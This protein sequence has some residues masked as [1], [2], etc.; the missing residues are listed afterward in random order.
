MAGCSDEDASPSHQTVQHR[1]ADQT[2]QLS[3]AVETEPGRTTPGRTTPGRNKP[4]WQQTIHRRIADGQYRIRKVND[5]TGFRASNQAHGLRARFGPRNVRVTNVASADDDHTLL[6]NLARW[7]R[8]GNLVATEAGELTRGTCPNE[9]FVDARGE[10]I[11]RVEIRRDAI[12]EWWHN[13]SDGL[14]QGFTI[15]R[16][17]AGVWPVVVEMAV[18]G[19]TVEIDRDGQAADLVGDAGW[20]LRYN[21][22]RAWDASGTTLSARMAPVPGGLA[23][24]VDDTGAHYPITIDPLLTNPGWTAESDQQDASFGRSVSSAGDVNADG[25]DDVIVGAYGYDNGESNEGRA[26]VYF[27]SAGGL[28]T[29]AAWTAEGDQFGAHFGWSVSSAGDVNADGFDDVIVG[30]YG[31]SN[32]QNDEGR[33]FVYLG[34]AGGLATSPTWTAESDQ[35]SAQFGYSVSSAGDV[36]ADGFDDV[37]VGATNYDSGQLDEGRA[38][39]YLGSAGGLATSPAWT[40]EGDQDSAGFGGSVSSAGDVNAD[41]FDDVIAGAENYDNGQLDEGRAFVYLG[42]AGGLATSPAWTAEGDQ[43]SADFGGSVSSAG[44]VNADGFDDVVVGAYGYDNG[45][46]DEGQ[47]LVYLGSAGGLAT[48]PAWTAEGDSAYDY[49]GRSVSSAGDVN[50]DGFDDVIVGTRLYSNGQAQE[51]RA[52]VY[53]G[54]AGGLA[55]SPAWTAE[56]DQDG[57]F[58]G[59]SVSHAGDLNG[60][61]ASDVIVGADGYDNGQAQE[62]RAFVYHGEVVNRA[63]V[64][65][66]DTATT[67]ENTPVTVDVLANDS[68]PD[69][70]PL[71]VD[72]DSAPSSGTA[73]INADDTITYTPATNFTGTDS[74]TY[75]VDDTAAGSN[76]A[77][78]AVTVITAGTCQRV[79]CTADQACYAGTCFETCTGDSDCSNPDDACYDQRCAADPCEGVQC[80]TDQACYAGTCFE[81]CT[82]DSDCSNPD[83]AC[84]DQRCATDPCEGVQCTTDQACYAGTCF[85]TCAGD[86]ECSHP[87]DA[88]YDQRCAK[89][90]CDGVQCATAQVCLEGACADEPRVLHVTGGGVTCATSPTKPR[91]PSVLPWGLLAV[92]IAAAGWRSAGTQ[93]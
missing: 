60:D 59:I 35:D 9:R 17:P 53:L 68:D 84:Y 51:G 31:Y 56:G 6:L 36:N 46:F 71:T 81:T 28:S 38:F 30:A 93:T 74:L 26:F 2:E 32:G 89:T 72:L 1:S 19:A 22:L 33:V 57:A 86:A 67:D 12:T 7:G 21:K 91:D 65:V 25:F 88:C 45:Q 18:E 29:S 63:P 20:T 27:G 78:V 44:D 90:P 54:S 23:V 85:E 47:A 10:C 41:G 52:V 14:E 50:A 48:S 76:I 39:V 66:D 24:Q 58:F 11:G 62:G 8:A 77:E 4:D 69:G 82:A 3:S 34:S 87:D 73:V 49:F 13:R 61:G 43:D 37:I 55:T 5:G 15:D 64:A 92:L 80:T 79:E 83:D 42:S 75:I 70:D 16:R 40:A